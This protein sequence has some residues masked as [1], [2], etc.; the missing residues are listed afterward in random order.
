M[1][2]E[3]RAAFVARFF[4][5]PEDFAETHDKLIIPSA[6]VE[7]GH[8]EIAF[9]VEF[10]SDLNPEPTLVGQFIYTLSE[11]DKVDVDYNRNTLPCLP[12][13]RNFNELMDSA[14]EFERQVQDRCKVCLEALR[15][16]TLE[17]AL[18]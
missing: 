2:R 16:L 5:A 11:N 4:G 13:I 14:P 8:Q 17:E 1:T 10:T 18:A 3:E 6:G 9:D 7:I 15:A 12:L